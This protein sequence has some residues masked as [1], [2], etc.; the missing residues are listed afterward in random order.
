L[1]N[2]RVV[3]NITNRLRNKRT[4]NQHR[5]SDVDLELQ[6]VPK[7][8]KWESK[9]MIVTVSFVRS[10]QDLLKMKSE[11]SHVENLNI[12]TN[13]LT[14]KARKHQRIIK[15]QSLPPN[16]IDFTINAITINSK[17]ALQSSMAYHSIA[18]CKYL[19]EKYSRSNKTI[20]SVWWKPTITL[21]QI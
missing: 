8:G 12:K 14:R 17:Y 6:V 16:P 1:D 21:S 19:Q 2:K 18:L 7:I 11:L 15:Y 9:Q 5:D 13:S 4:I 20:E 10:H 3:Q